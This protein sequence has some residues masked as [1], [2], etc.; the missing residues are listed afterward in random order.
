[1]KVGSDGGCH[2]LFKWATG[3]VP[4]GT[5]LTQSISLYDCMVISMQSVGLTANYEWHEEKPNSDQHTRVL[6]KQSFIY[7]DTLK[8]YANFVHIMI[9][10]R[11]HHGK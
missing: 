11:H 9:V 3:P 5:S 7:K 8:N 2:G 10:L 4:E 6:G 1:M